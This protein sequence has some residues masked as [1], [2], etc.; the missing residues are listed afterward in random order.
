VF[1]SVAFSDDKASRP[2]TVQELHQPAKP[3]IPASSRQKQAGL[4][5]KRMSR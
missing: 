4:L 5:K 2:V 3:A 1:I